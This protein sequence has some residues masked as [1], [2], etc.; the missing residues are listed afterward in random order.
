MPQDPTNP[1][2]PIF[3][4]GRQH[5]G[6]TVMA[7]CL[8]KAEGCLAQID[9]NAFFEHR[10]LIDRTSDPA[11]RAR[12]VFTRM[13]LEAAEVRDA[14]LAH[15]L[16]L[17]GERPGATALELYRAGMD[18]AMRAAGRVFWV[19]KA[20][21]YI[22]YGREILTAM[23]DARLL[24]LVR[25]PYD[26]AASKRRRSPGRESIW[27]TMVSWNKGLRL[28]QALEREFPDRFM[29]IRY[30]DLTGRAEETVS[31]VFAF[32]GV[33]F[34]PEV[35]DV[36]HVNKSETGYSLTGDGKGLNRSRVNNYL[37]NLR[38]SEIAALDMLADRALVEKYYPGLPHLAHRAGII[39]RAVGG[40]RVALGPLHYAFDNMRVLW[41]GPRYILERSL[42][43]LRK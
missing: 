34:R 13:K 33:P 30:E 2:G 6:N 42:H 15:V 37:K 43:R 39:T 5:S 3:I 20:T 26:I 14:T 23:P 4:S 32:L 24:F 27:N 21:S 16:A 40:L 28:G 22:F 36:P 31:R 17:A 18:F 7:V 41:R 38:A 12:K 9:E 29:I 10:A 25:N 1:P 8:G 19:Q 11:E 35:L